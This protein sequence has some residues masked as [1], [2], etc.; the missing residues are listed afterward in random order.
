MSDLVLFQ[1]VRK[2]H[3]DRGDSVIMR[4]QGI[5][6]EDLGLGNLLSVR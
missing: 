1:H 5:P 3:D 6:R 4:V 2:R